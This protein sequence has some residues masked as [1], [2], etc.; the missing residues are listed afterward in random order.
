MQFFLTVNAEVNIDAAVVQKAFRHREFEIFQVNCYIKHNKNSNGAMN[1]SY[2][3]A[4]TVGEK[5]TFLIESTNLVC[6][7][8]SCL[9]I[10]H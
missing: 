8:I 10:V 4:G 3:C 7:R 6:D 2:L 9:N 5:L 1:E